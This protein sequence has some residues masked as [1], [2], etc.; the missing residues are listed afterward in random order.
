MKSLR[1]KLLA[2]VG[3]GAVMLAVSGC[4][5]VEWLTGLLGDL[6]NLLPTA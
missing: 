4:T 2:L 3:T 6:T 1:S 5:P